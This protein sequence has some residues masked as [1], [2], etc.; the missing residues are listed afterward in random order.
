M[1]LSMAFAFLAASQVVEL[2][3][4]LFLNS[5][6]VFIPYTAIHL[7][8]FLDFLTL[9]SFSIALLARTSRGLDG[10]GK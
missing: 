4:A 3:E 8:H 1:F 10:T 6:L 9:S 2:V 5:Q 7:S